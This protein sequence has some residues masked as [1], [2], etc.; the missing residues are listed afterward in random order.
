MT[1]FEILNTL[2]EIRLMAIFPNH[3]TAISEAIELIMDQHETIKKLRKFEED[4]TSSNKT[5]H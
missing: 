1:R 2:N 4:G 3:Y 5:V